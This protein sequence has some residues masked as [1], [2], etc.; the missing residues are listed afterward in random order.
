MESSASKVAPPVDAVED[1][2]G[3]LRTFCAA[4]PAVVSGRGLEAIIAGA[5]IGAGRKTWLLPGPRERACALLRGCS[6]ERLDQARPYRV[7]PPGPSPAQRALQAVGLSLCGDR[8]LAF[9]GTNSVSYGSF[10]EALNLA[11]LHQANVT[12]VV[13]W[14][15]N[16]GPF[17]TQLAVSP[18]AIARGFGLAAEAVDGTDAAAVRDA[19]AGLTGGGVV[20]ARLVGRG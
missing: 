1:A 10:L 18:A 3:A 20:E 4:D 2:V 6:P 16:E 19:V 12:F 5:T 8:A 14:Y 15:V 17:A 11:A 13:S 7:V 9:L